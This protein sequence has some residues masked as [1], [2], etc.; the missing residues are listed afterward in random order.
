VELAFAKAQLRGADPDDQHRLADEVNTLRVAIDSAR[1]EL[2]R[3]SR[4]TA[5]AGMGAQ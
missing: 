2:A 3:S 4:H 5:A 1:R